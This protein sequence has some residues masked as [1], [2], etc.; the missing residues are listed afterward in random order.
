MPK[1][2]PSADVPYALRSVAQQQCPR[3]YFSENVSDETTWYIKDKSV[4]Q[5]LHTSRIIIIHSGNV[6]VCFFSQRL[7]TQKAR[8][9][10]SLNRLNP[11][12]LRHC[13]RSKGGPSSFP[14]SVVSL[15]RKS[16][17]GHGPYKTERWLIDCNRTR[18]KETRFWNTSS[19]PFRS[20]WNSLKFEGCKYGNGSQWYP[21]SWVL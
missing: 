9:P 17:G 21:L 13:L 3:P 6:R 1:D 7:G 5:F 16:N 10:D 2:Q 19:V 8:G 20:L 14:N 12:L 15:R 11:Q 18:Y 4:P